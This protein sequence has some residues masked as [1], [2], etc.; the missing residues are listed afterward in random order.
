MSLSIRDKIIIRLERFV[1]LDYQ[2]LLDEVLCKTGDYNEAREREMRAELDSL[3]TQGIIQC[4]LGRYRIAKGD[5][6]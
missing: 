3:R 6:S 4:S 1:S 5:R 2:A